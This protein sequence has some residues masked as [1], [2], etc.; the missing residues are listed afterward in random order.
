LGE[1]APIAWGQIIG[2][3]LTGAGIAASLIWNLLNRRHT[4]KIAVEVRVANF[5]S[6]Q[7][8]ASRSKIETA[9]ENLAQAIEALVVAL[10]ERGDP[11]F[12]AKFQFHNLTL[13]I[14]HE[15]FSEALSDAGENCEYVTDRKWSELALGTKTG[16]ET[17]WDKIQTALEAVGTTNT[18]PET[19]EA[20]APVRAWFQDIRRGIAAA[21]RS[22]NMLHDPTPK[23]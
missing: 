20:L 5:R 21:I 17:S 18:D 4:N 19:R 2:W 12:D 7:W 10:P 22:E 6:D 8:G 15:A 16:N 11:T 14:K 3:S 23:I 1:A 9:L 13:M